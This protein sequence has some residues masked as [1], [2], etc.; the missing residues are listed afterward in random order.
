MFHSIV[1][2]VQ[3][4]IFRNERTIP[5]CTI[6]E[7]IYFIFSQ[8]SS[9]SG[10]R[11]IIF[12][13]I[14][15]GTKSRMLS[16]GKMLSLF[17]SQVLPLRKYWRGSISCLFID[18]AQFQIFLFSCFERWK[19]LHELRHC[20]LIFSLLYQLK[21]NEFASTMQMSQKVFHRRDI[22]VK[23]L[24]LFTSQFNLTTCRNE[25]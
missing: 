4:F 20:A 23:C 16:L 2:F 6:S 18:F 17:H 21:Q 5:I 9:T 19:R 14:R 7:K 22:P 12:K 25:I 3:L 8:I 11:K 24:K 15:F 10:Q 1:R 13:K